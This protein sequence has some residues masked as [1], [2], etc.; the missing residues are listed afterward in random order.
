MKKFSAIGLMS[1]TSMDGIDVALIRSDGK[2]YV[3]R[4]PGFFVPYEA[5][6]RTEIEKALEIA[7]Q[8]NRRE[9]RPGDIAEL[10]RKLTLLHRQAVERFVQA[11]NINIEEVDLVGFH[12]QTIF[13]KPENGLTIQLGDGQLLADGTGKEVIYDMRASDMEHG[14]QGAPLVPVYHRALARSIVHKAMGWKED[15]NPPVAFV[16]IGGI[17]NITFIGSDDGMIAFDCGPGNNLID[18]WM[19]LKQSLKFDEGG[20]TALKGKVITDICSEYLAHPYFE[21]PVPKSLDRGDFKPLIKKNYSTEDGARSLARLTALTIILAINQLPEKPRAIFVC[22]G[23]VHNMAIMNDLVALACQIGSRAVVAD[24]VGCDSQYMEAE[25]F[26]YL[27]IRSKIGEELT[28]PMTTGCAMAVSGGK[29][30]SPQQ[31]AGTRR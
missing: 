28:F 11:H 20:Q 25:A 6:I 30:A 8:F 23:G 4:G 31:S 19:D 12:G 29:L 22:G 17:S 1:G 18:Q 3:E 2:G 14:G 10:E 5:Q 27:A 7:P 26:A 21:K 9:A 16:N 24:D 15:E 13:H